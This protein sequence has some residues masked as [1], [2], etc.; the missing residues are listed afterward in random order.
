LKKQAGILAECVDALQSGRDPYSVLAQHPEWARELE[1]LLDTARRVR[2]STATQIQTPV[3]TLQMWTKIQ[4]PA[5]SAAKLSDLGSLVL[6]VVLMALTLVV[7]FFFKE[8]VPTTS[9]IGLMTA[10]LIWWLARAPS[11]ATSGEMSNQSLVGRNMIAS[12][13][14]TS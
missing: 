11:R 14:R 5:R 3:P 9:Q 7:L 8:P 13:T 2:A 12:P 10:W 6:G 4:L 1:S